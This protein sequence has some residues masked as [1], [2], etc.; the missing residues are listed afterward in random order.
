MFYRVMAWRVDIDQLKSYYGSRDEALLEEILKYSDI[1]ERIAA[2][3]EENKKKIAGGMPSLGQALC[4]IIMGDTTYTAQ[5]DPSGRHVKALELLV[6]ACG[7][8]RL[9]DNARSPMP[10]GQ[11]GSIGDIAPLID[12]V[13]RSRPPIPIPVGDRIVAGH[14]SAAAVLGELAEMDEMDSL[15][16]VELAMGGDDDALDRIVDMCQYRDWLTAAKNA[17][18]GLVVIAA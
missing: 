8:T 14:M 6:E 9:T 3:D 17:A 2:D 4:N 13:Y 10:P 15:D 7:G 1:A 11:V 18:Q 16:W 5:N 12:L